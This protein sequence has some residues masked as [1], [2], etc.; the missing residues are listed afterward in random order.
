MEE[1]TILALPSSFSVTQAGVN[2]LWRAGLPRMIEGWPAPLAPEF[3]VVAELLRQK[4]LL[5]AS[6][7]LASA[8]AAVVTDSGQLDTLLSFCKKDE[9]RQAAATNPALSNSARGTMP[10][11]KMGTT[12]GDTAPEVVVTQLIFDGEVDGLVAAFSTASLKEA[13]MKQLLALSGVVKLGS[14]AKG[15]SVYG[16][17]YPEA[18]TIVVD[19][20][21]CDPWTIRRFRGA[22]L[23]KLA[24]SN[25]EMF[26]EFGA[27]VAK[28]RLIDPYVVPAIAA[29]LTA[30][31]V[32][33]GEL[34]Q[35]SGFSA[36][37]VELCQLSLTK[38]ASLHQRPTAT[39]TPTW[40]LSSYSGWVT[41]PPI[42]LFR[43]ECQLTASLTAGCHKR[44]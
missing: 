35:L 44:T 42:L 1:N 38:R 7:G 11:S 29:A 21:A 43:P 10:F 15:P 24:Q 2:E 8:L 30:G 16:K 40:K 23:G 41:L 20:N 31:A 3:S 34:G 12:A 18:T 5:Q 17:V 14:G 9:V 19:D 13:V 27:S 28:E 37:V 25:H 33:H 39:T 36:S 32:T 6:T 26:V 22:V 4:A